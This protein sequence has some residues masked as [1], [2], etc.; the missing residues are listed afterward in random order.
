MQGCGEK[1]CAKDRKKGR[2]HIASRLH[3]NL[4]ICTD[5]FLPGR[6]AQLRVLAALSLL[7]RSVCCPERI[8]G[9]LQQI[10]A[11]FPGGI[12]RDTVHVNCP[13]NFNAKHA[14]QAAG[15]RCLLLLFLARRWSASHESDPVGTTQLEL[16]WQRM[17]DKCYRCPQN[18]QGAD[19]AL[20]A[21]VCTLAVQRGRCSAACYQQKQ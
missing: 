19:K 13:E 18:W 8:I 20:G 7:Q 12:N 4:L 16:Q 11:G 10:M 1:C 3:A 21:Q 9:T 6:R 5:F 17:H 14:W 2:Q 15:A